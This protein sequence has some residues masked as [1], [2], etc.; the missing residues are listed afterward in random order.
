MV[1]NMICALMLMRHRHHSGSLSRA[2]FLSARNDVMANVAIVG[3]GLVT[4]YTRSIWPDLIVG[5]GI[6]ILNLDAAREVYATAR[7]EHRAE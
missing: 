6:A 5:I 1:V 2:A 3:A 4:V 7:A